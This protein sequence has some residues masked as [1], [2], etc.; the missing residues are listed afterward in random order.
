MTTSST[1][2]L[3]ITYLS[4]FSIVRDDFNIGFG[5]FIFYFIFWYILFNNKQFKKA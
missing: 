3:A 4:I 5:F 1:V 2:L